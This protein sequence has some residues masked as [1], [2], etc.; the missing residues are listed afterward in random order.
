MNTVSVIVPIYN[1]ENYLRRCIDSVVSQ[2][3]KDLEIIL[4]NDGSTD[5][6]GIICK[7]Y[8]ER[9]GRIIYIEQKIQGYPLHEIE[10]LKNQLESICTF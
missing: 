8:I 1:V 6:S 3:Y 5:N 9:D 7:D 10:G 4:V 2:T